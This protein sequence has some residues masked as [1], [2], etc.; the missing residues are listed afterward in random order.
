MAYFLLTL[1]M[2]VGLFLMFVILLQRGRGGGLGRLWRA[3]GA[4]RIRHEGR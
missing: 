2:L 1:L 4:K 3:G